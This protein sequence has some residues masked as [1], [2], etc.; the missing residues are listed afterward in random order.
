PTAA[1]DVAT[2]VGGSAAHGGDPQFFTDSQRAVA[3]AKAAAERIVGPRGAVVPGQGDDLR[4]AGFDL[5]QHVL[6]VTL[7]DRLPGWMRVAQ[8]RLRYQ[9]GPGRMDGQVQPADYG[10]DG[11][12]E[13]LFGN[14]QDL[15][16]PRMAAA[17]D[18]DQAKAADID[19]Q[20]LFGDVAEPEQHP[21][22]RRQ[23]GH[24]GPDHPGVSGDRDIG[25]RVVHAGRHVRWHPGW[26][27]RPGGERERAAA[28]RPQPAHM[29]EVQVGDHHGV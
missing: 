27:Q 21:R 26:L 22:Q 3:V 8:G 12:V 23:H 28:R 14:P 1:A 19:H 13:D 24:A 17:A 18:Q 15:L 16:D 5:L 20:R 7:A 9:W 2:A 11:D 10:L 6:G 4:P 29:V 25:A